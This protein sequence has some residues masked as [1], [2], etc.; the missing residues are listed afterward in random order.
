MSDLFKIYEDSLNIAINNIKKKLEIE[1]PHAHDIELINNDINEAH[2][3]VR[4][5]NYKNI[6]ISLNKWI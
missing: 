5:L 4:K 6:K 1:A 2:R 3:L